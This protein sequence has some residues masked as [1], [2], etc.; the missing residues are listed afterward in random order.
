MGAV[1]EVCHDA[2]GIIWPEEIAPFRVHLI[3]LGKKDSWEKNKVEADKIYEKLIEQGVEVLY[4]ER[5]DKGPGE[6]FAEAD[7]IGCPLRLV[8]S[9]KT[10][11]EESVEVKMRKNADSKLV[12]INNLSKELI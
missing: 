5:A 1:V 4:D 6:K 12:K 10:L 2:K 7:M 9:D 8:I 3:L 11:A